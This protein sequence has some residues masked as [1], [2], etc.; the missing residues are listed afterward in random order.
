MFVL[1]PGVIYLLIVNMKR[2]ARKA[3]IL[4]PASLLLEQIK[5][6][7]PFEVSLRQW[8]NIN[9]VYFFPVCLC[10]VLNVRMSPR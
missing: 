5:N 1:A 8:V 2:A 3:G 6:M 4:L 7:Q 9:A 10:E